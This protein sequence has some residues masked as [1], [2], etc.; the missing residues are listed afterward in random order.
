V[1]ILL[2]ILVCIATAA[3]GGVAFIYS[4]IYDVS[5]QEPDSAILRWALHTVSDRSVAARLG[6][7]VVPDGLDAPTAIQAGGRLW[8]QNCQ[9]C[10]GGAGIKPTLIAQGLNPAP[11]NLFRAGRKPRMN[12]MFRFIQHGVKMTGM[13]GFGRTLSDAQI[14]SLAAFL[15]T[16]PGITPEDYTA[17]TGP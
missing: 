9:V 12:E 1:K 5:A 15:R 11:P 13:P 17:R 6:G 8:A 10:H 4:G 7:I 3:L 2:T 16:A 14:W